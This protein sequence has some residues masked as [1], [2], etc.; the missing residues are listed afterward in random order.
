MPESPERHSSK[1]TSWEEDR[2]ILLLYI[3][4]NLCFDY[5]GIQDARMCWQA[6]AACEEAAFVISNFQSQSSAPAV[7]CLA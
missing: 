4:G 7:Y 1:W 5:Q 3:A 6:G 2:V